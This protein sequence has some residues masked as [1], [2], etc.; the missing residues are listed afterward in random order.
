MR[1]GVR[2]GSH[3]QHRSLHNPRLRLAHLLPPHTM[4]L[5]MAVMPPARTSLSFIVLVLLSCCSGSIPSK[6]QSSFTHNHV[7]LIILSDAL[8]QHGQHGNVSVSFI[9][10]ANGSVWPLGNISNHATYVPVQLQI[11]NMWFEGTPPPN[12]I[13]NFSTKSTIFQRV[14]NPPSP[15][16]QRSSQAGANPLRVWVQANPPSLHKNNQSFM[17]CVRRASKNLTLLQC[18]THFSI[19]LQQVA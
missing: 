12:Q 2:L 10:P 19:L 14:F 4:V 8:L 3:H 11:L 6:L 18:D 1:P 17:F 13:H 5:Q 16:N 7:S 9:K 15:S